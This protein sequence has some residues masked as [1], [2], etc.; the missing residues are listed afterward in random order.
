MLCTGDK[1]VADNFPNVVRHVNT[2]PF[3]HLASG[4]AEAPK[5]MGANR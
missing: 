3:D 1:I 2:L 4:V 5:Q